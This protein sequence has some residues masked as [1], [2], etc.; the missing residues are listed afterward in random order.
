MLMRS[1]CGVARTRCGLD[2]ELTAAD[3]IKRLSKRPRRVRESGP[4]TGSTIAPSE[5]PEWIAAFLEFK[6]VWHPIGV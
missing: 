1:T 2:A 3:T 5:R 4:S 6:T